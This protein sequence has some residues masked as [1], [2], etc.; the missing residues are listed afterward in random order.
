MNLSSKIDKGKLAGLIDILVSKYD[1][2]GPVRNQGQVGFERIRSVDELS[3]E[4]SNTDKSAKGLFFPQVETMFGYDNRKVVP[5]LKKVKPI[6]VFGLRPCDAK[7]L[8]ILNKVF[9]NGK[10]LDHYWKDRYEDRLIF[11]IGCNRP[12]ST[13]FCNWMDS[14]PFSKE[15]SDIF[16][17]DIGDS[18]LMEACSKKGEEFL[19]SLTGI[20][21]DKP[22]P[23]DLKKAAT[24]KG[25]AE[26]LLG[27]RIDVAAL[28]P[29]LEKVWDKGL[30]GEISTKCL[31]CGVCTYL[32]PTCYCF[33]IQDEKA[34][35]IDQGRR[36]RI[37]DSC[38]FPLFTRE[39]SGHNPRPTVKER[40][41]Q[42]VMHKFNYFI[43]DFEEIGCVGCGR[44][45]I[46]CP[47]N[48]DIREVLKRIRDEG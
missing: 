4:V 42:R 24:H 37:W 10:Y 48:L 35:G 19:K 6:A 45:V 21:L 32:C 1:L 7:G 22:S 39:A 5:P 46:A 20:D 26:A 18:F 11:T 25:D 27:D 8:S 38:M 28:K 15:G 40:L 12:R 36:I 30:W 16:L 47:V 13:C 43:S 2:F 9:G 23:D 31:S 44:C 41:R 34:P 3:L 14:G 17:T 29:I 33:D